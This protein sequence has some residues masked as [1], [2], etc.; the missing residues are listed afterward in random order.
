MM[1]TNGKCSRQGKKT[2]K[3][4]SGCRTCKIRRVKCDELW[5]VCDRCNSTGRVC[6]GYGV[7]G[8]GETIFSQQQRLLSERA[9]R[10]VS[11]PPVVVFLPGSSPEERDGFEWFKY[12]TAPKLPGSF[13]SKFWSTL[14][15]QASLDEPTVLHAVLALSY[16]HKGGHDVSK[17]NT[18]DHETVALRHYSRSIKGLQPHFIEKS[19]TS[20]RIALLACAVFV[21]LEMLRGHFQTAQ[22]H[23]E[24]GIRILQEMQLI[25]EGNDGIY[26]D[27]PGLGSTDIWIVEIFARMQLQ[28]EM[29]RCGYEHRCLFLELTQWTASEGPSSGLNSLKQ[30]WGTLTPL[31]NQTLRLISISRHQTFANFQCQ[32]SEAMSQT[33]QSILKGLARWKEMSEILQKRL[34]GDERRAFHLLLTYHTLAVIMADT[35]LELNNEMIYDSKAAKFQTLLQQLTELHD[36]SQKHSRTTVLPEMMMDMESSIADIGWTAVLYYIVSKCRVTTI[37]AQAVKL[38]ES[39]SHREGLWDSK[40]M[41]CVARKLVDIEE[42]GFDHDKGKLTGDQ[43]ATILRSHSV[44]V[45]LPDSHRLREVEVVLSGAPMDN[46]MIFGRREQDGLGNRVLLSEYHIL[47]RYWKD[48]ENC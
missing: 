5:P 45:P 46:I 9:A 48:A 15:H 10:T 6:E 29:F 44:E 13:Q 38:L 23:L 42:A 8:G 37:R 33:Q 3:V 36:A 39:R 28:S 1:D 43:G 26:R 11:R 22:T 40:V 21:N 35:A 17:C 18:L 31:L 7:W 16:V 41:A 2:K 14:L 27:V 24:N 19:K 4:K 30:A 20:C 12:R 32:T 47:A 34:L 25:S